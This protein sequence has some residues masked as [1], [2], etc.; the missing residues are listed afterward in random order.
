MTGEPSDVARQSAKQSIAYLNKVM[1]QYHSRFIV[2]EDVSSPGNHFHTRAKLPNENAP[3]SMD[4]SWADRPHSGA[5]S[6]RCIYLGGPPHS[7]AG[8]Y[9]QNGILIN[10]ERRPRLNFG[11][12]PNAGLDLSGATSFSCFS[13]V[14]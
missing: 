10:E 7:F 3:V 9:F 14:S 2:Y 6:T 1:D 4:G 11:E 8:F 13:A 5:T 12:V